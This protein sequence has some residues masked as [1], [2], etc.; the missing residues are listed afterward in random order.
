MADLVFRD[1]KGSKLSNNEGDANMRALNI[2]SK[3]KNADWRFVPSIFRLY[4]K[5]T[6]NISIDAKNP[7]GVITTAVYTTS[8]SNATGEVLYPF[9]GN[10]AA[11]MRINLTGTLTGEV[12]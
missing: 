7:D 6:G 3:I 1:E 10:D 8:L 11:Q 9:I 5:G 12:I 4:M 2:Y